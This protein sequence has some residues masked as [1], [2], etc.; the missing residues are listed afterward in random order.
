MYLLNLERKIKRTNFNKLTVPRSFSMS[1]PSCVLN[2]E[3]TL[4]KVSFPFCW[5]A[6]AEANRPWMNAFWLSCTNPS[7]EA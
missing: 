7:R 6:A 5:E 3:P 2:L 1:S 4:M